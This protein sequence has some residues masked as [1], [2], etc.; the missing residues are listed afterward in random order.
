[1]KELQVNT[2]ADNRETS[3]KLD[4][5]E[6]LNLSTDTG[7]ADTFSMRLD[8][9]SWADG[10]RK[11][12]LV[13]NKWILKISLKAELLIDRLLTFDFEKN[14]KVIQQEDGTNIVQHYYI[15]D[16]LE[17]CTFYYNPMRYYL[18]IILQ[19]S[20]IQGRAEKEIIDY[21]VDIFTYYFLIPQKYI[22]T[23][24]KHLKLSRIDFKRDYRYR[25]EQEL[26]LIKEIIEIA[27]EYIL[28]RNYVKE[29]EKDSHP[30]WD[31]Y[32]DY[33][34]MKKYKSKSNATAEFV[35]Y[36]KQLEQESKFRNGKITQDEL[37]Y[38][39]RVIRF[40]VRIKDKKL[41]NL[42][43]NLGISKD[44]D[45]YKDSQVA[46]KF[47]STYAEV[48]F[49]K[50]P[51]FRVDCA[52]RKINKSNLKPKTKKK[53]GKLITSINK[54]GY[55]YTQQHYEYNSNTFRNHIKTLRKLGINPLTFSEHWKDKFGNEHKTT[56]TKIPNFIQE[57]NCLEEDGIIP[58]V[59]QK[60]MEQNK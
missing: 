25:D 32:D 31:N 51:F 20:A 59:Y 22:D 4:K 60:L 46:D 15:N 35:I 44:I 2:S 24:H 29:D 7:Y 13:N 28:G 16:H 50:E 23:L 52:K 9:I 45:N 37:D 3:K 18:T 41:N 54:Y 26:A 33:V 40:E 34:Y 17:E 53:L 10:E 38:F 48:V 47:F 36:D 6:I 39:E 27:P 12:I 19:H 30:D 11:H 56:Y 49:F 14:S 57:K 5:V 21:I 58:S 1:M 55:T 42:K 43:S 8:M